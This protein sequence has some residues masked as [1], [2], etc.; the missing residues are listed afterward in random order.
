M[1]SVHILAVNNGGRKLRFPNDYL[2]PKAKKNF[3]KLYYPKC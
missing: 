3:S 2:Q 1:I